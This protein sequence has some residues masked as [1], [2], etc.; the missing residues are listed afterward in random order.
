MSPAM[1]W[2]MPAELYSSVATF[3]ARRS[4]YMRFP[5]AAEAIRFAVETMSPAQ[6]RGLSLECGDDR[7]EGE[8][9]RALYF[10]PGYPLQRDT[11]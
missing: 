10:A 3:G 8:A 6:L 4:R 9:I 5:S 2:S 11:R 1:D 7:H